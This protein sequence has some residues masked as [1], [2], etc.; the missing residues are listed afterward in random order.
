[1]FSTGSNIRGLETTATY[2]PA[3]EEFIINSP[4]LTS[5]KYWPGASRYRWFKICYGKP[6]QSENI[7][8]QYVAAFHI[9]VNGIFQMKICDTFFLM[10]A[11]NRLELLQ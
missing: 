5:M 3:T 1:M 11:R 6:H 9:S 7:P 10:S 4:T 8:V 2:D